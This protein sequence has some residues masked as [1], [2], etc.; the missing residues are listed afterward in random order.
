MPRL[1]LLLVL[2]LESKQLAL[3]YTAVLRWQQEG[4]PRWTRQPHCTAE[5][6]KNKIDVRAVTP[7]CRLYTHGARTRDFD[8]DSKKQDEVHMTRREMHMTRR[9]EQ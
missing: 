4:F 9:E 7:T 8:N 6:T 1:Q 5:E 3:Q 2:S